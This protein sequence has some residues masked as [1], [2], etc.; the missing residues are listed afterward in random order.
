ML[1]RMSPDLAQTRSAGM[2]AVPP[3]LG[4]KRTSRGRPN[5]VA[6]D[7]E[8]TSNRSPQTNGL[9]KARIINT[10]YVAPASTLPLFTEQLAPFV[11]TDLVSTYFLV[12]MLSTTLDFPDSNPEAT[13]ALQLAKLASNSIKMRRAPPLLTPITVMV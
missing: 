9:C 12:I 13:L 11:V 4:D 10:D 6:N 1:Q 3:L 8:R 2:S 7:P 5:S